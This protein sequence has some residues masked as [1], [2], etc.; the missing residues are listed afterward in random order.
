MS[1][2]DSSAWVIGGATDELEESSVWRAAG[3][4]GS[5]GPLRDFSECCTSISASSAGCCGFRPSMSAALVWLPPARCMI[6]VISERS[7]LAITM[8]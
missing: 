7:T 4:A 8:S 5:C 1:E 3:G 6:D 2:T